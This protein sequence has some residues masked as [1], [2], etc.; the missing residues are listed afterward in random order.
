MRNAFNTL[1]RQRKLDEVKTRAPLL[2]GYA[3]S[4]YRHPAA[5]FGQ[6][7]RLL[8]KCGVRQGDVCGPIMFSIA[9]QRVMQKLSRL[10]LEFQSWYLDDG[11]LCGEASVVDQ[12][13]PG[14]AQPGQMPSVQS[15]GLRGTSQTCA[16]SH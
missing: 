7:F 15:V 6:G 2:Y 11:I 4:C 5:L 9:L 1:I 16:A 10:D 14:L 13:L 3:R 12:A 8:S